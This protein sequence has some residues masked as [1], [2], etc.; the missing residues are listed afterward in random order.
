ML[1]QI[2]NGIILGNQWDQHGNITEVAIHTDKEDIYVLNSNRNAK[3]MIKLIHKKVMVKGIITLSPDGTKH[4][5]VNTMR[6]IKSDP[7]SR[8][9]YG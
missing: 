3:D 7:N 4:L 5:K 9:K 2:I 8:S 6:E 1:D